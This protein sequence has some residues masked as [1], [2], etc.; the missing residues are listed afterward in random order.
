MRG[1]SQLLGEKNLTCA[2]V[3]HVMEEVRG[4]KFARGLTL[5]SP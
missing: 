4:V 1:I 5:R 3:Q 2:I